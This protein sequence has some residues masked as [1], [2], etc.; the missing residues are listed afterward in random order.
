V[1]KLKHKLEYALVRG[2]LSLG[3]IFPWCLISG[4]GALLGRIAFH[5]LRIRRG[6]V[7][8]NLRL[9]L[10]DDYSEAELRRIA[11]RCYAQFGRS[12]M[13][14]FALPAIRRRRVLERVDVVGREN[15]DAALAPG[16]GVLVLGSHFGNWELLALAIQDQ[17]VRLHLLVGDLANPA[18]D[19]AMF[20]LRSRLGFP[21][22]WRGMGLR[23]VIKA[24]RSGETVGMQGDQ[25]A[26][27]HGIIVPF[28]GRESLTHP[29]AAFMSLKTGAPLLHCHLVRDG[30][31]F[32]VSFEPPLW[33]EGDTSDE[34]VQRLTAAH[35]AMLE[36]VI[37][38]HPDHWFWLHKRWKRAPRGEDGLPRRVG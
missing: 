27:W 21:I 13:E 37:R 25:E 12:Y 36:Q 10:G 14:Y 16:K 7:M 3:G 24:L 9:A 34:N 1:K 29:G 32:R 35:T 33:P 11:G 28:F 30:R 2:G 20:D 26:R 5:L 38:R 23:G 22:E 19:R 6:V 4:Q 8:D 17:G 18:V 31:R 15:L